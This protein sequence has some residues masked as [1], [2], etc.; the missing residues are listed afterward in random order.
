MTS[1]IAETAEG[2]GMERNSPFGILRNCR[3]HASPL[4]LQNLSSLKIMKL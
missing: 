3:P 2:V 4:H 1:K